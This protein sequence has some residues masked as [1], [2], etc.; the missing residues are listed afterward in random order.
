MNV[1]FV[2]R[3][4]AY[5]TCFGFSWST[6]IMAALLWLYIA[7]VSFIPFVSCAIDF[8]YHNHTALT[9]FLQS[10]ANTYPTIAHLHSIGKSVQGIDVLTRKIIH[11]LMI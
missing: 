9:L 1:I 11:L 5:I 4:F 10:V 2:I 6:K 7:T 3:F 8:G